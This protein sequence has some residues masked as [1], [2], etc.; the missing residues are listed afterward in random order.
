MLAVATCAGV[1]FWLPGPRT[2]RACRSLGVT[3]HDAPAVAA[4]DTDLGFHVELGQPGDPL[5]VAFGG[6]AGAGDPTLFEF[7]RLTRDVPSQR[8][9]LRDHQRAWYHHGVRG[10]GDDLAS[11]ERLLRR[12]VDEA[13]PERIV[14]VGVS[15]GGYA[16]MLFGHRVGAD[17]VHAFSPQTFLDP[18]LRRRH[19]EPRWSVE[20]AALMASGRH[21]P[22]ALDLATTLKTPPADRVPTIHLWYCPSEQPDAVHATHVVDVPTVTLHCVPHGDRLL[23]KWL[24]DEGH[25]IPILTSALAGDAPPVIPDEITP[26]LRAKTDQLYL[27]RRRWWMVKHRRRA[28]QA[29]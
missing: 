8:C 9:L 23:V 16:A 12:V 15:T 10:A 17:V 11:V 7:G 21:D 2:G 5:L 3:T 27:L 1:T 19:R 28:R 25:L 14:M 13:Q 18:V 22:R 24:R 4:D 29:R 26:R 20:T 6:M